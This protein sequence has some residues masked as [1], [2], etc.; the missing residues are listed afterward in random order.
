MPKLE[1]LHKQ[2]HPDCPWDGHTIFPK[3]ARS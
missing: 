3:E 2:E 1:A